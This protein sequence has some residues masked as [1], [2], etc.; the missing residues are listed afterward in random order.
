MKEKRLIGRGVHV[1]TRMMKRRVG[2]VVM[3]VHTLG[4]EWVGT[5]EMAERAER[6]EG[7]EQVER[8]GALLADPPW[9]SSLIC[10]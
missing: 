1:M 4:V 3:V 7:A 10:R 6:A 2:R 9:T 8:V 5:T